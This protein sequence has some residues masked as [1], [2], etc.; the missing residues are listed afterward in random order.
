MAGKDKTEATDPKTTPEVPP[1]KARVVIAY[2]A[3][4]ASR[5]GKTVTLDAEDARALV[6]EGRARY[7]RTP[8]DAPAPG[9]DV[10]VAALPVVSS[11]PAGTVTT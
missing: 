6:A 7:A 10:P 9:V 11:G 1:G 5:I 4:D 3:R 8:T 2:D